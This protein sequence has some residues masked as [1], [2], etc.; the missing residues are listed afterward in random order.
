VKPLTAFE[1]VTVALPITAPEGSVTT[2]DTVP[3]LPAD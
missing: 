1:S 2:P 3:A